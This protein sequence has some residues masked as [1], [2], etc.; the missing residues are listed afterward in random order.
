MALQ[1]W[2]KQQLLDWMRNWDNIW[3][4]TNES[5]TQILILGNQFLNLDGFMLPSRSIRGLW[6]IASAFIFL[7]LTKHLYNTFTKQ[8]KLTTQQQ[9]PAILSN[10]A[11]SNINLAFMFLNI[12]KRPCILIVSILFPKYFW[13][14]ALYKQTSRCTPNLKLS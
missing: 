9:L 13:N 2:I 10:Q 6:L 3:H 12:I 8:L 14:I 11:L 5:S 1:A 7:P 4:M